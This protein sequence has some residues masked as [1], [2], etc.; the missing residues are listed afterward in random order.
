MLLT[1]LLFSSLCLRLGHADVF[2]LIKKHKLYEAS[3]RHLMELLQLN[4]LV[5]A[6]TCTQHSWHALYDNHDP[7]A[8]L[9]RT[10]LC[11]IQF[12]SYLKEAHTC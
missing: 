3:L 12:A 1:S 7:F 4:E 8:I 11:G 9:Y 10:G 2:E 5:G 6:H